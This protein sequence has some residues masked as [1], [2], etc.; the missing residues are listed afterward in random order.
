M[1]KTLIA[2]AFAVFAFSGCCQNGCQDGSKSGCHNG[3]QYASRAEKIVAEIHDPHSKN[4]VVV[5]HRGD[6]RNYPE[7][8]VPA[9]E[10]IIR[11]GADVMELD[12]KLTKDS[13]LVLSHDATIDRCT[14]G[15]GRVS[16]YTYGELLGFRLRRAHGVVTD[17]MRICTLREALECCKD[18]IVV[19]VDQGY[20]FYDM[21]L[22]ITEELGVTD[23]ILIK[24]KRPLREVESK[25]A[26]HPRN[27]MYMPIIDIQ[28]EQGR[29]LF[30]EYMET[31]TVPLAYEVCW[32]KMTPEVKD[33]MDRIV[34]SGSK[35]W[36]N[37]IWGSLCGY[38]DDDAAL[39]CGDP[40][41]IYDQ[42]IATGAT[43]IQTDRPE[44]LL[45]YLR[46][47]GLHD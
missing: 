13:V 10:S 20:E 18:R 39:D 28:K 1:K 24:G 47:K 44:Q 14:N 40:A 26:A 31:G 19:N 27:M 43:M 11:M 41:M 17:S 5:V 21:V 15:K 35:L 7:N 2:V 25:M 16:D 30:N 32:K 38:L 34:R 22:D 12:L 42:V 3:R 4:V 6:W 37:T 29:N 23:Q 9:I 33:A 36:V 46:S 8:T 45:E